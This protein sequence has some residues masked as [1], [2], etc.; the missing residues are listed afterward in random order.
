MYENCKYQLF[1]TALEEGA[2]ITDE[3]WDT[4]KPHLKLRHFNKGEA[5]IEHG[6]VEN[7]LSVV[8]K[9]CVRFF[10][11]KDGNEINFEFSFEGEFSTSYASFLS[12]RPSF[13]LMEAVEDVTL[14]SIHYDN[15]QTLYKDSA[16]GEKIGRL[17]TEGYYI[18]REH[19][20]IQLLTLSAEELYIDLLNQYPEYI[21]RIP[22][23][24]L[25]SYLQVQPESLSR[26]KRRIYSN[27]KRK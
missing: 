6:Q 15:L 17:T 8:A 24:Y 22:Q 18:W 1:R 4:I 26:I 11:H 7:Y 12:R 2:P 9:G 5:I 10:V 25:A 27:K 13:V 16:T 21:N 19:R 20:E 23:K 3:N 14:I